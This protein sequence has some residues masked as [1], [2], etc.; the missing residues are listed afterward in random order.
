[1]HK[2]NRIDKRQKRLRICEDMKKETLICRKSIATAIV[3]CAALTCIGLSDTAQA[4]N[5]SGLSPD[6]QEIVTLSSQHMADDV[7]TN[8][9]K[10]SAKSYK[11]SATDIIYLNSQ[12]VSQGVISA[13]LQT[14]PPAPA[15]GG[16]A[17][18]PGTPSMPPPVDASSAPSAVPPTPVA[19]APAP[20]AA[21]ATFAPTVA[22]SPQPPMPPVAPTPMATQQPGVPPTPSLEYFQAQL[23]PYGNWVDLPGYGVCWQPAVNFG[24]RPYYDGGHWESTDAGWYWQSEYPW[25]D[26]AFH[27][28]RWAYTPSG[29]V[30]VPGYEYA[31]AWVFWR[32]ADEDGFIGW[33]PLP[34]GAVFV[35]GGWRFHGARVAVDFDFGLG[36]DF[37]TFVGC[38][39]FWEHDYRRFIVPRDRV[40]FVFRRSVIENHYRFEHGR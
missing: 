9:I 12:G 22:P 7:I 28:G 36:V 37:F 19:P 4:Q 17:P 29:W 31:P 2:L 20:S 40:V 16:P 8:Y 21:P 27:Y 33:A 34:V 6:L 5:P 10:S 1:M 13:L 39:H 11:L 23:T 25:G 3:A 24:W 30:W 35:E 15:P 14:A 26:L 18:A 32:H 38:D